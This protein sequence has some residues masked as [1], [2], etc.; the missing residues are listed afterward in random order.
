[1]KIK[2]VLFDLGNVLSHDGHETYLTHEL[3]GLA[4]SLGLPKKEVIQKVTHIFR[5]Y[6]VQS[7]ADES[8]FWDEISETLGIE[9]S[10]KAIATVKQQ[11]TTTNPEAIAAFK[12]L[13][14]HGIK[15]GIIS[16]SSPFFYDQQAEPL[17]LDKYAEPDL[18]FLSH[19][20]GHLKSNGLFEVAAARLDPSSTFVI[21]DRPH[22][23]EYAQKLGFHAATYSMESGDSLLA[24]TNKI[25][26]ENRDLK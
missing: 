11:I 18:V 4:L 10:P 24:L 26:A 16:N 5:K 20:R 8:D 12:L 14:E 3:Y 1:M 25:V 13:R 7:E 22:N 23:V 17:L 19:K 21:D 2:T 15:I 9:L 6:A